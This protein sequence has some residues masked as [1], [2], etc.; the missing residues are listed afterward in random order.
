[1]RD[2]C[3]EI[4]RCMR[5]RA[6]FPSRCPV[7]RVSYAPPTHSLGVQSKGSVR[8]SHPVMR[9]CVRGDVRQEMLIHDG[10]AARTVS[11]EVGA[12]TKCSSQALLMDQPL[13][14][15]P[16][17]LSGGNL[18]PTDTTTVPCMHMHIT[19]EKRHSLT[20]NTLN[21]VSAARQQYGREIR[22][23]RRYQTSM[24]G[25]LTDN[26]QPA[27]TREGARVLPQQPFF[28]IICCSVKAMTDCVWGR[29]RREK[30]T[31]S[32]LLVW[33]ETHGPE[34]H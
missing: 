10:G 16:W 20:N 15:K 29:R 6:K 19:D 33:L 30:K 22:P 4:L 1:M 34:S 7:S 21:R 12:V 8:E 3:W 13:S 17:R 32:G 23:Q 31:L 27:V 24:S 14:Y 18:H 11:D 25:I 28:S 2:T 26:I 9:C 5:S